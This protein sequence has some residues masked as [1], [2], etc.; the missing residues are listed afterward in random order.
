MLYC[1]VFPCSFI[2]TGHSNPINIKI[3]QNILFK[4]FE[5]DKPYRTLLLGAQADI[6]FVFENALLLCRKYFFIYIEKWILLIRIPNTLHTIYITRSL[7]L[8]FLK[9][10]ARTNK[11][12]EEW[13]FFYTYFSGL[14]FSDFDHNSN[15]PT[16]PK[17]FHKLQA[18]HYVCQQL[19]EC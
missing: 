19:S 11:I 6:A 15:L 4:I 7:N 2:S 17:R 12:T 18:Q 10:N 13:L 8:F 3:I 16:I 9:K 1:C 5:W 14:F